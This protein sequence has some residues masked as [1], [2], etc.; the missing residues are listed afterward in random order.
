[1]LKNVNP[2]LKNLNDCP[3][4]LSSWFLAVRPKTLIA[5][6]IPVLV[7]SFMPGLSFAE[8]DWNVLVAALLVSILMTIGVNLVNDALDCKKGADTAQRIGPVRVTQSGL[9]SEQQVLGAAFFVLSLSLLAGFPLILKGGSPLLAFIVLSILFSYLYTGGPYP[10]SYHGLGEIFVIL[11]YG[12]G[13]VLATYYLQAGT[14]TLDAF[15]GSL[16]IG[17]LATVMISINNLRDIVEDTQ[18]GKKT[19]AV[20]FGI[21]F[22][23]W[24][25]TILIVLPFL[26]NF[27]WYFAHDFLPFFLPSSALLI[28]VNLIRGIWKHAPSKLYNR[29]L[30]EA[31]LLLALFGLLLTLGINAHY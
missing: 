30:G 24:E 26:L 29:F 14:L 1:M 23:K 25:I 5:G 7:G 16:Q 9:L 18:T 12:F 4:P 10:L 22:A 28:A 31:S 17:L 13:A 20:R 27:Y 15:V 2:T 3:N 19:L 21:D 8:V 6:I 11:F